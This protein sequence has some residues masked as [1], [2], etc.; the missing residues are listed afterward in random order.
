MPRSWLRVAGVAAILPVLA[1]AS[2]SSDGASAPLQVEGRLVIASELPEPPTLDIRASGSTAIA[3]LL[4]YNVQETLVQL[5]GAG[6]FRPLLA[7]SWRVSPNRRTYTFKLRRG[8]RFH[9]GSAFT[10]G[11]VVYSFKTAKTNPASP[12]AGRFAVVEFVKAR[13]PRAVQVTLKRPSFRFLYDMAQR[14][15]VIV[16]GKTAGQAASHPIGTGPFKFE[17]WNRGSSIVLSR[18]AGYWGRKARLD[19][20]EMRYIADPNAQVNALLAGDIDVLSNL[21]AP[22]R[23]A[24]LRANTSFTFIRGATNAKQQL[25]INVSKPPLNNLRVR[26][27][28]A[29]AID[30]RAVNVATFGGFGTLTGTFAARTDPY[31]TTYAPY[32]YNPAKARDLLSRAGFSG[33]LDLEIKSIRG[34]ISAPQA[35]VVAAQLGRVGI[36]AKI[37]ELDFATWASTVFNPSVANF[38]LTTVGHSQLL[39]IY[40]FV[41][42]PGWYQQYRSTGFNRLM[43]AADSAADLTTFTRLA[44]RAAMRLADDAVTIPFFAESTVT[45]VRK[46][47]IGWPVTGRIDASIDL[48]AVRVAP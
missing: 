25:S 30:R 27:A 14:A 41:S 18:F 13:G 48:R 3:Q 16:S 46:R 1:G 32:P 11:D 2:F 12:Q 47:V 6:R 17:R 21:R 7:E 38:Q 23:A 15:G 24:Q 20:V 9:D 33:G 40:Q 42:P 34:N 36:R 37:T 22:D 10:S 44:R 45:F 8:V 29:Y 28:I 35:E 43:T 26:Q 19:A 31:F 39:E 4:I 5:D